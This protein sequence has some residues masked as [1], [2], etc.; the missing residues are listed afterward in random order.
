MPAP[1][2]AVRAAL[3]KDAADS[4]LLADAHVVPSVLEANGFTFAHPDL[5]SAFEV[6]LREKRG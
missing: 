3:G 6:A 4:L 1:A 2:F 5:E